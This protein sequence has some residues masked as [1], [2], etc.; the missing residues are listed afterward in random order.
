MVTAPVDLILSKV[1]LEAIALCAQTSAEAINA[2]LMLDTT[3]DDA[4]I[5]KLLIVYLLR[6]ALNYETAFYLQILIHFQSI[7]LY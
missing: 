2:A 3:N 5:F 1:A 7:Y 4:F 6:T